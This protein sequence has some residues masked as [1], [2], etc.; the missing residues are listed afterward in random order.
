MNL[1]SQ[2]EEHTP[3]SHQI[4]YTQFKEG[5]ARLETFNDGIFAIAMTLLV[6]DLKVPH[7]DNTVQDSLIEPLLQQW[8]QYV[9][10]ITSFTVLGII[11]VNHHEMFRFIRYSDHHFL[12]INILFLITVSLLPFPTAVLSHYLYSN[13]Q[14]TIA[15]VLY[16]GIL[17]VLA[18]LFNLIWLYAIKKGLVDTQRNTEVLDIMTRGYLVAPALFLISFIVAFFWYKASLILDML[19][20]MIYLIPSPKRKIFLPVP[21]GK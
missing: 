18:I 13:T 10:F 1:H 6:I 8:P 3:E 19:I 21:K 12:L 15:T 14:Q 2:N 7:L 5:T 20:Y 16:S 9:G 17:L 11:W 4:E